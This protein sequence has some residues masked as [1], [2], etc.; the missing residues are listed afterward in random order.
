MHQHIRACDEVRSRRVHPLFCGGWLR[1][2][3]HDSLVLGF[4]VVET[5]C[6][7]PHE[8]NNKVQVAG[9]S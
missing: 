6:G 4:N 3:S 2:I 9:R 5:L 1:D 8:I 7:D